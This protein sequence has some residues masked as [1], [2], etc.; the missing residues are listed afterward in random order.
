VYKLK[1]SEHFAQTAGSATKAAFDFGAEADIC[2]RA[3]ERISTSRIHHL[4]FSFSDGCSSAEPESQ[5]SCCDS[6]VVKIRRRL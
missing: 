2:P 6:V 5:Q 3:S 1:L 4:V